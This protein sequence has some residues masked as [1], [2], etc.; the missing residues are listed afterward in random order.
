MRPVETIA[1]GS[2]LVKG[3]HLC[4]LAFSFHS[5]GWKRK[6]RGAER[7]RKCGGEKN[8][9]LEYGRVEDADHHL[10]W[11]LRCQEVCPGE[12]QIKLQHWA[13]FPGS[14]LLDQNGSYS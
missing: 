11:H 6:E 13:H 3:V 14:L 9:E 8:A 4:L 2:T 1:S 5:L 10:T 12:K 7:E